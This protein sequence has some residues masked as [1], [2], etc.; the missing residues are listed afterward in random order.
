MLAEISSNAAHNIDEKHAQQKKGLK[1]LSTQ[2]Q[3]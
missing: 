3:L 1:F 2:F